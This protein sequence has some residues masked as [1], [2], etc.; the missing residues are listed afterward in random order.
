[1]ALPNFNSDGN[2]PAGIHTCTWEEAR[3]KLAFNPYRQKLF[4]NLQQACQSLKQSGC[5]RIYIAGSFAS[6]KEIPGDFDI[7]WDDS[8]V[9]FELLEQI[10]PVLLDISNNCA[11]QKAKYGGE[12][13][14]ANA[15]TQIDGRSHLEFFQQD[16]NGNA[17]GLVEI[18]LIS[19]YD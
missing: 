4:F 17:K 2:L 5:K 3:E 16:R 8:D 6:S 19:T 14:P 1:M 13:F 18:Y 9:N 12:M 11:A 10:D 7:C 15:P